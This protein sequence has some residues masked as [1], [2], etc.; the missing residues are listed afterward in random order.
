MMKGESMKLSPIAALTLMLLLNGCA[1]FNPRNTPSLNWV[2][3]HLLPEKQPK[4][5]LVYPLVLPVGLVA[6]SIDALIVHP[7]Q[8]VDDAAEDTDEVLWDHF[9]WDTEYV[10][11]CASLI[12]RAALTPPVFAIDFLG[13]SAFDFDEDAPDR[14][15]RDQ[16][17][18]DAQA[19]ENYTAARTLFGGG[20]YDEAKQAL[21]RSLEL[22]ETDQASQLLARC[23][24]ELR[25]YNDLADL[26]NAKSD[27]SGTGYRDLIKSDDLA[28]EYAS[29][30]TMRPVPDQMKLLLLIA[31]HV[32]WRAKWMDQEKP[33]RDAVESFV[34]SENAAL[35][36]KAAEIIS[37]F[38]NSTRQALLEKVATHPDPAVATAARHLMGK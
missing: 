16:R 14:R 33:V 30:L 1:V 8:V 38:D 15:S 11:E 32:R 13:R 4:R 35:A 22:R 21:I 20:R 36:L 34:S 17:R 24:L 19:E 3:E 26:F 29:A 9:D 27:Y 7:L 2:D 10:T 23:L 12:P 28:R 5:G 25:E 37:K 31:E 18:R 6:V